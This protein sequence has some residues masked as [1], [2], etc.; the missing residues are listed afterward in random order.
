MKKILC[1]AAAAVLALLPAMAEDVF[2]KVGPFDRLSVRGD[3]NV[4]Y[5]CVPDSTGF[6]RYDD[7]RAKEEP[8]ELYVKKG[9]LQVKTPEP[10][11]GTVTAPTLYVYSDFLTSVDYE[12]CGTL[13]VVLPIATPKFSA[14]LIGNGKLIVDG[15]KSTDVSINFPTGNGTIVAIGQ[16]EKLGISMLGTGTVQADGL[17]AD[18]VNC[19]VMGTGSIGCW[20]QESLDVRGI[21]TTKVYYKGDPEVH[22]VGGSKIFPLTK[23]EEA[24]PS[25]E[26]EESLD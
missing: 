17:R 5:R 20:A 2:Y 23:E 6:A 25:I 10:G 16:C 15:I 11:N 18:N 19:N 12:G 24:A 4:V 7:S 8:F 21:G 26:K 1:A 9:K 22:K 13:S 14:K 3:I